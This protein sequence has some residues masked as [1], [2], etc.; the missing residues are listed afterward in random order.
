MFLFLLLTTSSLSANDESTFIF[1]DK[2]KQIAVVKRA[3]E[4]LT[5]EK[6]CYLNKESCDA[7][8][9]LKKISYQRSTKDIEGGANPGAVICKKQL[10][11]KL[12]VLIDRDGN[13]HTFC[14][15]KDDSFIGSGTLSYYASENDRKQRILD[16]KL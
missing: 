13:E 12:F 14:K 7:M 15:F 4:H 5:V 2:N 11:M 8:L 6:N 16:L 3:K 9:A 10:K 1:F